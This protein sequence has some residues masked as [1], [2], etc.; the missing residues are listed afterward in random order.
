M[1]TKA[2]IQNYLD[3]CNRLLHHEY[4]LGLVLVHSASGYT[5]E[6]V[7][8][9]KGGVNEMAGCMTVREAYFFARGMYDGLEQKGAA[10]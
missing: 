2:L 10:Q 9:D 1:T 8:N 6:R 4:G 3:G 5:I 7:M